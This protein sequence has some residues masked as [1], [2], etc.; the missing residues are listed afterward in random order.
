PLGPN[1]VFTAFA[2]VLAAMIFADCASRP[3]VLLFSGS[4]IIIGCPPN[5]AIDLLPPVIMIP[6]ILII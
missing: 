4:I 3:V 2:I 1:V 5:P 6:V